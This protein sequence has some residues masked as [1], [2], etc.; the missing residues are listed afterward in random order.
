MQLQWLVRTLELLELRSF[1][2]LARWPETA[3]RF[4]EEGKS[5]RPSSGVEP[6]VVCR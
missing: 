4:P 6:Q 2:T 5:V 1:A 3:A